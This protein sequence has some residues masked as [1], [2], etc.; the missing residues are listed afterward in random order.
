MI[1]VCMWCRRA[2]VQESTRQDNRKVTENRSQG[3]LPRLCLVPRRI[4]RL[5]SQ[6]ASA[7][8]WKATIVLARDLS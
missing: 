4:T 5:C 8:M 6:A 2:Q 3:V 7:A 1:L